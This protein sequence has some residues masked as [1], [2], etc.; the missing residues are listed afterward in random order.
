[1]ADTSAQMATLKALTAEQAEE[2]G[3]LFGRPGQIGAALWE[4]YAGGAVNISSCVLCDRW[5]LAEIYP[6]GSD[7]RGSA[8]TLDCK[9]AQ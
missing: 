4:E 9:A 8:L 1:M 5:V 3:H 7:S 6:F 2:R